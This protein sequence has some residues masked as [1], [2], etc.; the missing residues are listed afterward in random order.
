RRAAQGRG[1]KHVIPTWESRRR[2]PSRI[3]APVLVL[4]VLVAT[5]GVALAHANLVRSNPPAGA[6]LAKAPG[7]VQLWFSEELEPSFSKATV[8]D[9]SRQRVDIGDSHVAPDDP[10]SLVVTMRSGLP[11]GSYVVSW[12]S[13][14][15]V[16]G[17]IVRG[18]VPFG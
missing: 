5:F 15:R 2:L 18:L 13:Q 12:E 10:A 1:V 4:V 7:Y 9:A 11:N 8:L 14:S 17:H 16:D 6:S 3:L